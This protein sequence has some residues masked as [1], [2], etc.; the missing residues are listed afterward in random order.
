[1]G[2]WHIYV[3]I[4]M[5]FFC[6]W[7]LNNRKITKRKFGKLK[8]FEFVFN[9]E[10]YCSFSYPFSKKKWYRRSKNVYTVSQIAWFC[11]F[12]IVPFNIKKNWFICSELDF[13]ETLTQ[14]AFWYLQSRFRRT[15]WNCRFK[16]SSIFYIPF[17]YKVLFHFNGIESFWI[18]FAIIIM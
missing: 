1:M 10:I 11:L 18:Y 7:H 9:F 2:L 15:L 17:N 12:P 13:P 8:Y 5:V 3:F 6:I 16:T 14:T 4:F